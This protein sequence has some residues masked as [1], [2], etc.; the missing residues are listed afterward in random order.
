MLMRISD[1]SY[2][3]ATDRTDQRFF[4][5]LVAMTNQALLLGRILLAA[6]FIVAGFGKFNGIDG[7]A[8][9]LAGKGLPAP[10]ILAY[11]VAAL[12]LLGG[13]AIAAGFLV[14]P[15]SLALAAFCVATAFIGHMGDT[16]AMLKNF[17]IAGGFLV[18]AA[19]G[20][21]TLSVQRNA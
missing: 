1:V 16:T 20:S 5:D 13:L 10:V 2:R 14:R 6:L 18:L 12:E 19:A 8:G 9:M 3:M 11:G 15:L 4:M 7:F 17:A 21:G